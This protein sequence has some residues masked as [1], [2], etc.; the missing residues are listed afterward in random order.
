[1]EIIKTS[2]QTRHNEETIPSLYYNDTS[3]EDDVDK[4]EILNDYFISQAQL[5]SLILK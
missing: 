1:M 4:A 3:Y 5:N 2:A